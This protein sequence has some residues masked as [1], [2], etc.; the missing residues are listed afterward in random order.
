MGGSGTHTEDP[1]QV[2]LQMIQPQVRKRCRRLWGCG[3]TGSQAG[4]SCPRHSGAGEVRKGWRPE[5]E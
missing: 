2:V 3:E 4:P 1:A 5:D